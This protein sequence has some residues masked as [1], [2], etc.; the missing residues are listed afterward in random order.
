MNNITI[1]EHYDTAAIITADSNLAEEF[2]LW[3]AHAAVNPSDW[4]GNEFTLADFE[5]YISGL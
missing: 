5:N 4:T 3:Q 2:A 1:P